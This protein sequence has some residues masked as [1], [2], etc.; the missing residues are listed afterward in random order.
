MTTTAETK[1]LKMLFFCNLGLGRMSSVPLLS[2][3]KGLRMPDPEAM[4]RSLSPKT[5]VSDPGLTFL[6]I[7][8]VR[9]LHGCLCSRLLLIFSF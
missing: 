4:S 3:R 2:A 5:L 6:L 1:D 9:I 7:S 8:S